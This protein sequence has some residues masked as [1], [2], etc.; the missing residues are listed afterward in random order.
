MWHIFL[1]RQL[2]FFGIFLLKNHYFYFC[3]IS[4]I[5]EGTILK[6]FMLQEQYQNFGFWS[7]KGSHVI[8]DVD[9]NGLNAFFTSPGGGVAC[10]VLFHDFTRFSFHSV[11]AQEVAEA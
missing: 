8:G 7:Q 11:C 3:Y 4:Y 9:V 1:Y 2:V 10:S 6:F 5:F